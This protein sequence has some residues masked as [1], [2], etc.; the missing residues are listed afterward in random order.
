MSLVTSGI[1]TIYG[2]SG[3]A[4]E[5]LCSEGHGLHSSNLARAGSSPDEAT[6]AIL[7]H[8]TNEN[9]KGDAKWLEG[10]R[11]A[12]LIYNDTNLRHPNKY[13]TLEGC[14]AHDGRL[15]N[16]LLLRSHLLFTR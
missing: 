15:G 14:F 16:T 10:R 9:N 12:L 2:S 1:D 11:N 3:R 8:L 5:D 13:G 6:K 7:V 4:P